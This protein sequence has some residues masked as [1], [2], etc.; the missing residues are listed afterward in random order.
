MEGPKNKPLKRHEAIQPL[1]REHHQGLLLCWKIKKGFSTG[2]EPAR[3]KKYTDWFWENQLRHHFRIEEELV[4][5]VLGA[6]NDLVEQALEE[7]QHL[8]YLFQEEKDD[9]AAL[10]MI[11]ND[12]ETHIRFEERVLFQEIQEKA[13]PEELAHIQKNHD[14]EISC[15]MWKDEFWT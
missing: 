4:F 10:E 11:K 7:H 6:N 12:L 15:G 1:S 3:M 2:V 5:P 8:Q 9:K 13:S 14:R